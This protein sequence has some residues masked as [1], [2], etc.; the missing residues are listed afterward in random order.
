MS[1]STDKKRVAFVTIGQ[2]PRTDLVPEMASWMGGVMD[3]IEYGALD[4]LSRGEIDEIAPTAGDQHLVTRLSDGSEAIVGKRGMRDRLQELLAQ[5]SREDFLA[6]V[7]LCTGHF[8][9]L[10]ADR[11]FLEAQTI[12]DHATAAYAASARSIGVIVP[13]AEQMEEFHVSPTIRQTLRLSHSS[14]YGEGRLGKAARELTDVDL[15]VMHCIGYTESMRRTVADITGRPTL[16]ARRLV[17][18]A[19]AQLV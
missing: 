18:M 19:V 13:L 7:L 3:I 16:L 17:A 15:I 8:E 10:C 1:T 4:G 9:G 6:I 2:T 12:V 11:L 14:P 5:L